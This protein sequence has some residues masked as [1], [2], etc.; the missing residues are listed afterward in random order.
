MAMVAVLAFLRE[1]TDA[2]RNDGITRLLSALLGK[3]MAQQWVGMH[4]Q[5]ISA[6]TAASHE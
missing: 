1:M 2:S 6:L 3:Y 4:A 5:D